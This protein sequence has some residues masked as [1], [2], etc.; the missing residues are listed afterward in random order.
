MY[1][2]KEAMKDDIR[3][4]I[5]ENID[6]KERTDRNELEERLQDILC[7]KDSVTGNASGSNTFSR[8]K[9]QEYVLDNIDLLEEACAVL[10]A[11]NATVGRWLLASDFESMDVTIRCH[12][13]SQCIHEVLDERD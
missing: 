6:E 12:L 9:A 4:Y 3:A 5:N 13:L 10:G 8:Y 11:D 7:A 2:Y 1:D